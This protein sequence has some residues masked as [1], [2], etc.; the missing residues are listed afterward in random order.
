MPINKLLSPVT[1]NDL[2]N[3][4]NE[5][6][7]SVG[8]DGIGTVV[9]S[10]N[11]SAVSILSSTYTEITHV[12]LAP[13]TWLLIGRGH[14]TNVS[15]AAGVRRLNIAESS[16]AGTWD[17]SYSSGDAQL[18]IEVTKVVQPTTQ[19]TYYL[20]AWQNSGSSLSC[21]SQSGELVAVRII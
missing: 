1:P 8:L 10:I 14:F 13:G 11:S 9:S 15:G 6:I 19:K 18:R 12:T 16:A 7:D 21:G 4:T 3:K 17:V 5:I 2:I 20:N